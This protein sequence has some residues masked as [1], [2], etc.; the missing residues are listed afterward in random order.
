MS[1]D[2]ACLSTYVHQSGMDACIDRFVGVYGADMQY[3]R[4][5]PESNLT[6]TINSVN[7]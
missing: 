6:Q 3:R 1:L 4:T 2:G 5:Y 7:G